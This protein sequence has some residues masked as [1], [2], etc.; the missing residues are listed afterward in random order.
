[1]NIIFDCYN[2]E[3]QKRK[4]YIKELKKCNDRKEELHGM[5]LGGAN[6]FGE[7]IKGG[8]SINPTEDALS[9]YV[10]AVNYKTYIKLEGQEY[11]LNDYIKKLNKL[12]KEQNRYIKEI[13]NVLSK[14]E[15]R[16][17]ELFYLIKV[18]GYKP[19][20]AVTE[21]SIKYDITENNIWR[22]EYRKIK[23]YLKNI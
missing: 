17:A 4:I 6:Q 23:K 12:I 21:I 5:Y 15:G 8:K 1:M 13:S 3:V 18:K 7:Y 19:T 20:K 14:I 11:S 9:G 10:D 16:E 2:N 22:R